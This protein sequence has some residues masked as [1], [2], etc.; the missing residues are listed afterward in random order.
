MT[1]ESLLKKCQI[2]E[3]L[4]LARFLLKCCA[5]LFITYKSMSV[6]VKIHMKET[7]NGKL[8]RGWE[9]GGEDCEILFLLQ[10]VERRVGC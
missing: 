6:T 5:E 7:V 9:G 8:A 4:V 10:R 1:E 2:I 3:R